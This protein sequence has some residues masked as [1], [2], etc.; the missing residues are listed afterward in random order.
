LI[1]ITRSV[2][3]NGTTTTNYGDDNF[4]LFYT[5][6][7][8]ADLSSL[9]YELNPDD[10]M[11][12]PAVPPAV[13][14]VT[15]TVT[16]K[17][18]LKAFNITEMAR[19]RIGY[20]WK[21]TTVAVDDIITV[22]SHK[23]AQ[24]TYEFRKPYF[25]ADYYPYR[26]RSD[27][28]PTEFF[29]LSVT[30]PYE[31][32]Y[33][34]YYEAEPEWL[35]DTEVDYCIIEEIDMADSIRIKEIH[36]TLGAGEFA[37]YQDDQGK[38]QPAYMHIA[39]KLDLLAKAWGISFNLDGSIM[40]IRQRKNIPYKDG[41]ATVPNGWAR[42]QFKLNTGDNNSHNPKDYLRQNGGTDKDERLGIAY[43]QRSNTHD[44]DQV[45][46]GGTLLM[47][48]P[49]KFI[50][51]GDIVLCENIPQFY[52]SF[53]D[54]LDKGLNWQE[55]GMCVLPNP[56][57]D[58]KQFKGIQTYFT[59]EG[60]GTLLAECTMMLMKVTNELQSVGIATLQSK[61]ILFELIKATGLPISYKSIPVHIGVD[62]KTKESVYAS[63]E[64]PGLAKDAPSLTR[65]NFWI[66]QNLGSILAAGLTNIEAA[67]KIHEQVISAY[68]GP[69]GG[70]T[71]GGGGTIGGVPFYPT[72]N[73]I[74]KSFVQLENGEVVEVNTY[75]GVPMGPPISPIFAP[76]EQR[77][78]KSFI[79]MPDSSFKVLEDF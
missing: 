43:Q 72:V 75:T 30:I 26:W 76:T 15:F 21:L 74:E 42:G 37:Y 52:E 6:E 41:Q 38:A 70:P 28:T 47:T 51:Q 22:E 67:E 66:L 10:P 5:Y 36:A 54:D 57:A 13:N 69:G 58:S 77:P 68:Y 17:L 7:S 46:A 1:I 53:L 65:Q 61:A 49:E 71:G 56:N 34:S 3:I 32:N 33:V 24:I 9:Y 25:D 45:G 2:G 31:L 18:Y 60:L 40:P 16:S 59:T 78:G 8:T 55:M 35:W 27:D 63:A 19:E 44:Y 79:Q 20:G 39:R 12:P 11:G 29:P 48:N 14:T 73:S 4:P 50:K 64:F 23:T 62:P